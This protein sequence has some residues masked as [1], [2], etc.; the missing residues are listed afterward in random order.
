MLLVSA[1]NLFYMCFTV[2]EHLND[3]YKIHKGLFVW[4]KTCWCSVHLVERLDRPGFLFLF[5]FSFLPLLGRYSRGQII[6]CVCVQVL[7]SIAARNLFS[8]WTS[9]DW[10]RHPVLVRRAQ[11]A[12][13][14][15]SQQS[16]S[17]RNWLALFFNDF[18]FFP[19]RVAL[20]RQVY[21]NK[22]IFYVHLNF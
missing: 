13:C 12:L 18:D 2:E 1:F 14:L 17:D 22:I 20:S 10:T 5:F 16:G 19:Y 15:S 8:E 3:T 21:K 11:K 6:T 9:I 4:K 7:W